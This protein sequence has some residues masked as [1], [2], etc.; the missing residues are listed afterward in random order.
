MK[1][2]RLTPV[3]LDIETTGLN[4]LEHEIVA[5]G[6]KAIDLRQETFNPWKYQKVWVNTVF[7]RETAD[8]DGLIRSALHFL[9]R[10]SVCIIGYNIVGFDIPFLTAR[11]L[12]NGFKE[13]QV[14]ALRQQYRIDLMHVVTRY[15]LTN[16]RHIK[17]ADI[18]AFLGID[19]DDEIT[20]KD[21]PELYE[22]GEFEK[23]ASH[24]RC[25]LETISALFV[26]LM[27]LCIHNLQRRYNLDCEVL[28][29]GVESL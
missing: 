26:K 24:C 10:E 4:P 3:F 25:D 2:L 21:I 1:Y 19:V 29:E 12:F 5:I 6:I 22:Q 20:G 9:T 15:L 14:I 28:L 27:D 7:T 17:L 8:E 23:I 16:N 11:A 18:A 13:Y